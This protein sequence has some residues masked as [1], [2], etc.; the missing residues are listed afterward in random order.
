MD[1]GAQTS[2]RLAGRG[3]GIRLVEET[4]AHVVVR[5]LLLLL[6]LL[7]SGRSL[8]TASR[9]TTG[10]SDGT[11]RGHRGKLLL[12]LGDHIGNVLAVELSDELV[13]AL[14]VGLNTDSAQQALDVVSSRSRLLGERKQQKSGDVLD[15]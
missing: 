15:S 3:D 12:A 14:S 5:L 7:L 1:G 6:L 4:E 13:E 2:H 10:G 11:T 8:V 9:G